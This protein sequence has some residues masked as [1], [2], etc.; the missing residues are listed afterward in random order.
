MRCGSE[1]IL[2]AEQFVATRDEHGRFVFQH[3]PGRRK[4]PTGPD[5]RRPLRRVNSGRVAP[6]NGE[7]QKPQ[8]RLHKSRGLRCGPQGCY[9]ANQDQ[10]GSHVE[11]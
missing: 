3:L 6:G 1:R 4:R 11:P 5:M 2:C 7:Q 9:R 8:P 10:N